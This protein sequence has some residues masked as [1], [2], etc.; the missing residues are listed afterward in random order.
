MLLNDVEI[1]AFVLHLRRSTKTESDDVILK[2]LAEQAKAAIALTKRTIT[3]FVCPCGTLFPVKDGIT[4]EEA[5]RQYAKH[6]LS[7]PQATT[8]CA[9]CAETIPGPANGKQFQ[10]HVRR[11]KDHPFHNQLERLN[12]LD[13]HINDIDVE[14]KKIGFRGFG[15]VEAIR[16]L[17]ERAKM[18]S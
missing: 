9:G 3:S 12:Y 7:C 15:R 2:G 4:Y 14:L 10:E 13:W 18:N 6:Q 16:R 5:S 1:D 11:C 17:V 8:I